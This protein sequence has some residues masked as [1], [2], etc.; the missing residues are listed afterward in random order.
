MRDILA[1]QEPTIVQHYG[2]KKK[3]FRIKPNKQM[4]IQMKGGTKT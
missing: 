1:T 4:I 3:A 2:K